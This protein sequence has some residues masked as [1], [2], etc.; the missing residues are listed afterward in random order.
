MAMALLMV[1]TWA[2]CGGGGGFVS[3]SGTGGTPPGTSALT[4]TGTY[5]ATPEETAAGAPSQ[6]TETTELK[7]TVR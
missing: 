5:T 3:N 2:A 4:I 1:L 6:L 7:L